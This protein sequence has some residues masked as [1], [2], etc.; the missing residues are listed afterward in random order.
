[1]GH[2]GSGFQSRGQS[3]PLF[4]SLGVDIRGL[5]FSTD[6][7][8]LAAA[9]TGRGDGRIERLALPGL[10]IL[11]VVRRFL[12]TGSPGNGIVRTGLPPG[13]REA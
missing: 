2:L 12:N 7:Q 4:S 1:V 8:V 13:F 6:C 9:E 10:G 5:H 11:Y 3:R